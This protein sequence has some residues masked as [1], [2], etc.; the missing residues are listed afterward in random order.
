MKGSKGFLLLE[1][2]VVFLLLGTLLIFVLGSFSS[3]I[4]AL[5][6]TKEVQKA[7]AVAEQALFNEEINLPSHWQV[8]KTERVVQ[9]VTLKE[10]QILEI[11]SGKVIF[12]LVWAQ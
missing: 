8:V 1:L 10:V 11:K 6:F 3:C 5:S 12:N 4:K 2:A 9:G 7:Q